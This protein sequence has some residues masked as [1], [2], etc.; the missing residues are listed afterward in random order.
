MRGEKMSEI[1]P[2]SRIMVYDGETDAFKPATVICRY[3][4]RST[5]NERWI[6]PDNVDVRFD[7]RPDRIS[8]G[9]FT[10]GVRK[11]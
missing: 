11:I 2:D 5:Y 10:D 3:G 1:L 7:H 4:F 6:Y 8:H 9:H